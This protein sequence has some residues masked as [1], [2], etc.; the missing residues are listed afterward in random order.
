[1]SK[2]EAR[3]CFWL[4]DTDQ[5]AAS[6]GARQLSGCRH[7]A[8]GSSAIDVH[9]LDEDRQIC[10]WSSVPTLSRKLSLELGGAAPLAVFDHADTGQ[11]SRG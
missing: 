4:R 5:L 10:G 1:M 8:D 6:N 7:R 11:W 2:D 9:R 3:H